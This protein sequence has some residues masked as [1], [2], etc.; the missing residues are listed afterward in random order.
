MRKGMFATALL[1]A[2]SAG[3]FTSCG[4]GSS[5]SS[6][7]GAETSVSKTAEV[8]VSAKFPNTSGGIR[9]AHIDET[10]SSITVTLYAGCNEQYWNCSVGRT[11]TL[12]RS[13]PS[14]T[15]TNL[16]VGKFRYQIVAK[17]NSNTT[18]DYLK[19]IGELSE[20]RNSL[21]AT[22]IRAKW[23]FVDNNDNPI[24]I[25]LNKTYSSSQ[26]T[27]SH[28]IVLP[29]YY[30]YYYYYDYYGL[31]LHDIYYFGSNLNAQGCY[32]DRCGGYNELVYYNNF[33]NNQNKNALE[34]GQLPL[35]QDPNYQNTYNPDPNTCWGYYN[36]PYDCTNRGA[37]IVGLPFNFDYGY[38]YGYGYWDTKELTFKYDGQDVTGTINDYINQYG[39]TVTSADRMRGLMI[40]F[41]FKQG[42]S[43]TQCYDVDGVT[44]GG[45]QNCEIQ[46]PYYVM[47]ANK[48]NKTKMVLKA[49]SNRIGKAQVQDCYRDL[50]VSDRYEW[51]RYLDLN[52]D[53]TPD[54]VKVVEIMNST[55]DAC[56]HTFNAKASQIPHNDLQLIIQKK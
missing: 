54:R 40:E 50:Q 55:L 26:E 9:P 18:V 33:T 13:N 15:I 45:Q 32:G 38:G 8:V 35:I 19:G 48:T 1:L 53:Y 49:L 43:Q 2:G 27:I 12:T 5:L 16:P 36:D 51:V 56:F 30:Y 4:G 39:T 20:G 23:S 42:Q 24:S 21:T 25:S 28:F 7:G 31:S 17:D 37:I 47:K 11:V 6:T 3:L 22:L 52:N 41:L 29:L 34:N 10:V 44:C 14:A 46:C